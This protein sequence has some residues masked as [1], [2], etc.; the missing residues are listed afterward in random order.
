MKRTRPKFRQPWIGKCVL[1]LVIALGLAGTSYAQQ[2]DAPYYDL[3]KRNKARWASE[4]K[5]VD[6][7]LAALEKRFGKKPNIIYILADDVG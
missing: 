5:Q 6:A 7:K 1:S 2:F 4:D 3:K